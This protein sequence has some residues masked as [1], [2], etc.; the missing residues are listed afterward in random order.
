MTVLSV[1]QAASMVLGLTSPSTVFASTDRQWT[2]MQAVVN[3]AAA[4]IADAFDWQRLLRTHT[5]TGNGTADAFDLPS[6]FRRM[7]MDG[8]LWSSRVRDNIIHLADADDWLALDTR[9]VVPHNGVWCLFGDQLHIRPVMSSSETARFF[10]VKNT[11]VSGN[12]TAFTDDTDT[13]VLDERLLKLCT[14]YLWKQ[15]KQQDFTA[16]LSDYEI[17]LAQLMRRDRGSLSIVSGNTCR[18]RG[19]TW[20]GKVS[21]AP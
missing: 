2:E 20:P 8:A 12:K 21:D 17:L 5:I 1:V 4:T 9:P 13:F 19:N 10:Y 14:I 7:K 18:A 16:E 3:E 15:A 11:I 6:D